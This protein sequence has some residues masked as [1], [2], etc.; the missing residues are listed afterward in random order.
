MPASWGLLEPPAP[1]VAVEL[2]VPPVKIVP[3]MTADP[4]EPLAP[5]L[6]PPLTTS[7]SGS[8]SPLEE[9]PPEPAPPPAPGSP[10]S[11]LG[12]AQRGV[13]AEHSPSRPQV[14]SISGFVQEPVE[15]AEQETPQAFPAHAC[16]GVRLF[17]PSEFVWSQPT[18]GAST[19]SVATTKESLV[20]LLIVV[21]SGC[22][23]VPDRG[24]DRPDALENPRLWP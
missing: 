7:A 3:P 20:C 23:M 9:K 12:D 18:V 21:S 6:P 8:R 16:C 22:P 14:P 13:A 15:H 4:A 11:A 10:A 2:V 17:V 19:S 24:F 5:A 1:A